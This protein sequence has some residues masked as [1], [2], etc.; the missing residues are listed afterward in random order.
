MSSRWRPPALK[1]GDRQFGTKFGKHAREF[2]IE[3]SDPQARS[4]FRDMIADVYD[5]ADEMR[6]GPWNPKGNGGNDY[7]FFRRGNSVLVT[8]SDGEFVT[9]MADAADNTWFVHAKVI[10]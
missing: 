4:K 6:Q 9:V 2:G 1:V 10:E 7:L 3:F 5:N 8:K